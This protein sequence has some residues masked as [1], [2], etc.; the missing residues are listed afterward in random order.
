VDYLDDIRQLM[1]ALV[2]SGEAPGASLLFAHRGATI[3]R[4]AFGWADVE[5][6]RPLTPDDLMWIGS[7]TRPMAATAIVQLADRGALHLDVP[8]QG[9]L[10][11]FRGIS[12]RGGIAP[13]SLPTTRQ[14]LAQTSGIIPTA[15]WSVF[16]KH[17]QPFD[18]ATPPPRQAIYDQR[19]HAEALTHTLS[20][21]S[22]QTARY[23]LGADPGTV[24]AD[25]A[26]GFCVAGRVAEVV[27]G[28]GFDTL[29]ENQLLRPLGMGR[30]TFRPTREQLASIPVRYIKGPG[31]LRPVPHAVPSE[32]EMRL[33]IPSGGLASTLDDCATFLRMH[34]ENG[35]LDSTRVLS[36][37]WVNEMRMSY[38]SAAE[39]PK[40]GGAYGL[41]WYI[42]RMSS[43]ETVLSLS[44]GGALG[45]MLWIDLDRDLIGVFLT[46]MQPPT[47]AVRETTQRIQQ[48]VRDAI[49]TTGREL[50][51]PN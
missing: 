2:D 43:D 15:A 11:E 6:R 27:A 34:L 26:A 14:I 20:E 44:H 39:G 3:F 51:I 7:S 45:S 1:T 41:G 16:W 18:P 31:G 13:S 36:E 28:T 50:K 17:E 19:V 35:A 5:A 38:T 42:E 33:I 22:R 9:Y 29:M 21:L 12:M 32:G 25:S 47:R 24:F 37:R 8:I 4:E 46:Q 40:Q 23:H 48:I 49:P 30:T 10:P